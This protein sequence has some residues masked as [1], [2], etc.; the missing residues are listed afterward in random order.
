V[1]CTGVTDPTYP[2]RVSINGN[3]LRV[4]PAELARAQRDLGT[5]YELAARLRGS[6][7]DRW[8]STDKTWHALEF[9]LDRYGFSVPLVLGAEEFVEVPDYEDEEAFAAFEES[10]ANW[11]YGPPRYL[12]PRQVVAA[13]VELAPLGEEDLLGGVDLAELRREEIYPQVWDDRRELRWA[14]HHLPGVTRYFSAAAASG[15][16]VICW[17]D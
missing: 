14:T 15:D 11:G 2:A 13:A 17:L 7:D 6:D 16:A 3:W 10:D 1:R 8:F 4:T 5:A 9:L 12:N